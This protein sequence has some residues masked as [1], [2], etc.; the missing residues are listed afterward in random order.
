[1]QWAAE[2]VHR[3]TA[4]YPASDTEGGGSFVLPTDTPILR[5]TEKREGKA[6]RKKN[7]RNFGLGYLY[8]CEPIVFHLPSLLLL[9]LWWPSFGS[10]LHIGGH[11]RRDTC[12][13]VRE[14]S[15]LFLTQFSAGI[16]GL[17]L[18]VFSCPISLLRDEKKASQI[19]KEHHANE[20]LVECLSSQLFCT[21]SDRKVTSFF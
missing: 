7:S 6:T 8:H 9:T 5:M 12:S 15:K 3:E 1:M 4:C 10:L 18:S 13:T 20:T 19:L 2:R 14:E 11:G 16:D 21:S 17:S